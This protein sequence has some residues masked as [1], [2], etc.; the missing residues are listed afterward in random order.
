MASSE[1]PFWK[2]AIKSEMDSIMA[3]ETWVLANLPI[4][5]KPIGCKWI[6]KKNL[7][8]YGSINKCK[9]RLMAKGF[10]QKEGLDY[11]DTYSPVSRMSTYTHCVSYCL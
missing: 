10:K 1:A 5:I 8:S 2:E 6:F 11:F 4:G 3:H 7:N 9:A